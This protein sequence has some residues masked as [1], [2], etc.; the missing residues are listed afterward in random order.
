L[1]NHPD[2]ANRRAERAYQIVMERHSLEVYTN[3]IAG[4]MKELK[5]AIA[6]TKTALLPPESS[7]QV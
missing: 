3:A 7:L 6:Q 2:E 4:C 1:L 5:G